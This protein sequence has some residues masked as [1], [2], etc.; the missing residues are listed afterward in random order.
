MYVTA[1]RVR[2]SR[3]ETG[4][5]SF[6]HSHE[7]EGEVVWDPPDLDFIT[8]DNPG[9]LVAELVEVSPGN[10]SVL[11]YLDVA[12]EDSATSS[13][14]TT[15]LG[16]FGNGLDP[17]RQPWRRIV[18]GF[19][20]EFYIGVQNLDEAAAEFGCLKARVL[21]LV[22]TRPP[23]RWLLETPLT[24]NVKIDEQAAAY[25]LD[26][27]SGRRVQKRH[28]NSWTSPRVAI[29]HETRQYFEKLWGD[30]IEHIVPVLTG[31]DI[32][33]VVDMGGVRFVDVR[34]GKELSK[35]PERD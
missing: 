18:N 23:P 22:Q 33:A 16:T 35:W 5:N 14:L 29:E 17:D 27:E 6:L 8:N 25:S 31:L 34:T 26:D 19:A 32:E 12:V 11:S 30:V 4:I 28:Q 15:A 13:D 21:Q 20:I 2:S 1:Q 24:V 10:N 3:G 7:N 9:R